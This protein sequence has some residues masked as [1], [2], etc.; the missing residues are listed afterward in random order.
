MSLRS[1]TTPAGY[2]AMKLLL[3][4]MKAVDRPAVIKLIEEAREHGDLSEN[5]EYDAAKDKQGIL[6]ARI[7][8][9][10]NKVATAQIID[11][12]TIEE[13]RIVFGATVTFVDLDTEVKKTYQIVGD[14][15]ANLKDGRISIS[16]PL[17]RVLIGRKVGD[18]IDF[19]APGGDRELEVLALEYK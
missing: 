1:P 15:E 8:D 11:P 17:A 19:E 13:D 3:H 7:V 5:A 2:E 12:S 6:E 4:R 18:H 16:A 14:H 9:L 10:E